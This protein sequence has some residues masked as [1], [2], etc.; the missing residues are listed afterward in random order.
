MKKQLYIGL[1]NFGCICFSLVYTLQSVSVFAFF[2]NKFWL[3]QFNSDLSGF[4][5][6]VHPYFWLYIEHFLFL[7]I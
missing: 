5:K 2:K 4:E 1:I 3:V 6:F 7:K